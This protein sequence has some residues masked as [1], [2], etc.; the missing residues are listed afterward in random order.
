MLVGAMDSSGATMS[1]APFVIYHDVIDEQTDG[2][3]E[4]C[5]PVRAPV[6]LRG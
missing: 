3:I 6:E 1:G 4:V 5:L 2:D